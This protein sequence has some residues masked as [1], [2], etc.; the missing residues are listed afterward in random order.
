MRYSDRVPEEL[1]KD[2]HYLGRPADFDDKIVTRR[3][4][5]VKDYPGF[6]GKNY[7]LLDIGCGNGASTL[8]L[9]AEMKNCLG[10][11]IESVHQPEF[12]LYKQTHHITNCEFRLHNL[13]ET[14]LEK[15]YDR[16]I[17]FEVIE[18]LNDDKSVSKY[19]DTL[20]QGGLIAI[21]VPNKWWVFE[22]H[23]ANLPLLPWNRVPFF[24]WLPTPIHERWAKARIYTKSRIVQLMRN[25]GFEILDVKY[26]TAPMD[27]LKDG[28]LKRFLIKNVFNGDTTSNP[29]LSTSIMVICKKA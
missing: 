10:I 29:C 18:H 15:Q 4:K 16:I 3:V 19:Y 1:T 5:L 13:E 23:G 21:T 22:T 8:L 7:E 25:A 2:G 6:C 26:V 9:S 14:P 12:E 27:V 11:D 28:K 20:K 24:S 17:S